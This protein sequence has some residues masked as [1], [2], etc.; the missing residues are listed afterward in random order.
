MNA[1]VALAAAVIVLLVVSV[2]LLVHV[3]GGPGPEARHDWIVREL[4]DKGHAREAVDQ[5]EALRRDADPALAER[6]DRSLVRAYIGVGDDPSLSVE[7]ATRW[8]RRAYELDSD[9]LAPIP[10]RLVEQQIEAER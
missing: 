3:A 9:A 6:I 8:H 4:I 1:R 2:A 10:R 7:A 5:L